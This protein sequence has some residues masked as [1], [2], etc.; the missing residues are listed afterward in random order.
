[1]YNMLMPIFY[2]NFTGG[3]TDN[4]MTYFNYGY[5]IRRVSSRLMAIVLIILII[6]KWKST[7]LLFYFGDILIYEDYLERIPFLPFFKTFRIYY[8]D[9]IIDK[10]RGYVCY[11]DVFTILIVSKGYLN[12]KSAMKYTQS[13]IWFIASTL[14]SNTF[15]EIK[16]AY[17]F[18]N[19][20]IESM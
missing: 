9:A 12:T 6:V 19:N 8:S 7:L 1:M 17:D 15:D 3:V 14:S 2:S 16:N 4:I 13:R 5:G 18:L 20:N 11:E 10:W